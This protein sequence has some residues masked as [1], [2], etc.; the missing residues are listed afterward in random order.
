MIIIERRLFSKFGHEPVQIKLIKDMINNKFTKIITCNNQDFNIQNNITYPILLDYDVKNEGKE[1]CNYIKKN[2]QVLCRFLNNQNKKIESIFIPSARNLEL[3]MMV[4]LFNMIEK[5]KCP[6][7]F[8]R[9]LND[10]FFNNLNTK[11]KEK[12]ILLLKDGF[13]FL[14][15]E[16]EEL[17]KEIGDKYNISCKKLLLP[18]LIKNA[19]YIPKKVNDSEFTIGFLGSPRSNKGVLKIPKIIRSFRKKL[20][21]V[22]TNYKVNFLLQIGNLKQR[23][24]IPF[25]IVKFISKYFTNKLKIEIINDNYDNSEFLKTQ[26]RVDI[27]LLPY[28]QKSYKFSGSGFIIDSTMLCKPI[29][30]T[31]G[32]A[33]NEFLNK[34]NALDA[35][36]ANEFADALHKVIFNYKL[37]EKR[38]YECSVFLE[39]DFKKAKKILNYM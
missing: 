1:S 13:I 14:F 16:T 2:A 21:S 18:C 5:S 15:S 32:I 25:F 35:N 19:K 23:K 4:V 36:T 26:K 31:S 27:F 12:L 37:F 3:S 30:H 34:G 29:V 9:I 8:I 24:K 38:S 11:I 28:S 39:Q 17:A 22:E 10:G 33:M 20:S 7:I 6:K